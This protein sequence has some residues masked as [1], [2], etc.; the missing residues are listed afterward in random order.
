[1]I[2]RILALILV[3]FCAIVLIVG[4]A[5]AP[6]EQPSVSAPEQAEPAPNQLEPPKDKP[7]QGLMDLDKTYSVYG[8]NYSLPFDV[9]VIIENNAISNIEVTDI[10]GE[11]SEILQS[12]I[13]TYIPRILETQSLAVDTISGAT[14]SSSGIYS[15]VS[16]A[17]TEA[18]GNVSGWR[19]PIEKSTDTVTLKGYDAIVVGLGGSGMASYVSAAGAGAKVFGIETAAKIGGTSVTVGGPMAVNPTYK[20]DEVEPAASQYPVDADALYNTWVTLTEGKAKNDIIRRYIDQSGKTLDWLANDWDFSFLPVRAFMDPTGWKVYATY[21][22][23]AEKMYQSALEKAKTVSPGSDYMLEL[24]AEELLF[25][26]DGKIAGVKA[27]YYDGTTY[28]VYAPNVILATGGYAGSAEMTKEY[29]GY[30]PNIYGMRQ[31]DGAGIRMALS[32]GGATYNISMPA[33]Q[34]VTRTPVTIHDDRIDAVETKALY[35]LLARNDGMAVNESGKRFINESQGMGISELSWKGGQYYYMLYDQTEIDRISQE[36]FADVSL[37]LN[38]QDFTMNM[39]TREMMMGFAL[40]PGMPIAKMQTVMDVGEEYN[41]VIKADTIEEL[42]QKAGMPYLAE[43]FA[44]Y[45]S[46]AAGEPDPFCKDASLIH[47]FSAMGPYY[48]VKGQGYVYST[49]GGLDID[50]NMN[51]LDTQGNPIA[52]LYATGT[53][54]MSVLMEDEYLEFGGVAHG[55]C[56]VSGQIAGEHAAASAK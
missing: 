11:T 26:A 31:N 19:A 22:G 1:M 23:S 10:G 18:G 13:D 46:Y 49:C 33:L 50:M 43:T 14:A 8:N 41:V 30:T 51:V 12:A 37:L 40:M 4:C 45:N 56:F 24:T 35:N 9:R 52:G 55:W 3:V 2:K 7:A 54:T 27:K 21:M 48:L 47:G 34:H 42:A 28:E 17:I 25:D 6:T 5:P 39:Q 32:A 15:A 20:A 38:I 53:D 44:A 36:G 29:L 16:K